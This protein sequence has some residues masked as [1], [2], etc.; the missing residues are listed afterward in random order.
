MRKQEVIDVLYAPGKAINRG[1][2]SKAEITGTKLTLKT[3][4]VQDTTA[5]S[6]FSVRVTAVGK[7][8]PHTQSTRRTIP[9][10]LALDAGL[11]EAGLWPA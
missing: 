3:P 7:D 5:I 6:R 2:D 1:S 8:A 10:S 11:I 4:T 9:E